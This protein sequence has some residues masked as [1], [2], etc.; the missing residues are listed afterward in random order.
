M[1]KKCLFSRY[2]EGLFL[3]NPQTSNICSVIIE[4]LHIGLF[5]QNPWYYQF[6]FLSGF[7]FTI[8]HES[9]HRR[10]RG[11]GHFFNSLLPL[12][13]AFTYTRKVHAQNFAITQHT[14]INSK[15]DLFPDK[16]HPNKKRQGT[17]KG[18]FRRFINDCKF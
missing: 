3:V 13:P 4:I 14:N 15:L 6:F 1:K 17:L 8:I 18:N 9:Q 5:L 2:L 12:P 10:G 7:S 11:R 16:L